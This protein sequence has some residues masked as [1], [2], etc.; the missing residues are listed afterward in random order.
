MPQQDENDIDLTT[1]SI[2]EALD[3][4][5]VTKN[6]SLDTEAQIDDLYQQLNRTIRILVLNIRSQH[7]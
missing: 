4:V 7:P 5:L 3:A 2:K 6:I 1:T